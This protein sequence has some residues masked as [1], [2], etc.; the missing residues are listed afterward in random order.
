MTSPSWANAGVA[1][2]RMVENASAVPKR[3]IQNLCLPRENGA[4][5]ILGCSP[6]N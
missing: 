6:G 5:A 2:A 1:S 3:V 4:A